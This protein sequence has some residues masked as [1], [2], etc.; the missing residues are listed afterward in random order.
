MALF[1]TF[2]N[3]IL[4]IVQRAKNKNIAIYVQDSNAE[5][6]VNAKVFEGSATV[7]KKLMEHPKENG[8]VITDHVIDDPS[9]VN[10]QLL[11]EDDDATTI[12]ELMD[13]YRNSTLLTVKIK[14]EVFSNLIINSKPLSADSGHYDSTIYN[15]SFKE[16]QEAI[17]QYVKMPQN[18]V[19]NATNA[20]RVKTGQKQPQSQPSI[21][22]KLYN[23]VTK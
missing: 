20:G 14:N 13:Y 19:K 15:L 2:T 18:Q 8:T 9:Q 22:R 4:R 10:I 7:D 11:I 5:A 16:V 3:L 23:K 21:L 12:N 17:T 6:L 1:Q